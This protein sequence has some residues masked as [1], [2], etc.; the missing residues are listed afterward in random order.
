MA[1]KLYRALA[2]RGIPEDI[3]VWRLCLFSFLLAGQRALK[4]SPGGRTVHANV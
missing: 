3:P 1:F 2:A 4:R